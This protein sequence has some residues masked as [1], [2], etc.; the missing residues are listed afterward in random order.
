MKIPRE[1]GVAGHFT[2]PRPWM[3][4]HE[5]VREPL[6]RMVGARPEEVVAMNALTVNL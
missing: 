2:G 5:S 1:L 6:A 4:Y 3:S